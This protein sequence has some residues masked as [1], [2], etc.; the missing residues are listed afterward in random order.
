M[1]IAAVSKAH[2]AASLAELQA[3]AQVRR[4]AWSKWLMAAQK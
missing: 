1:K 2:N 4:L 3:Q